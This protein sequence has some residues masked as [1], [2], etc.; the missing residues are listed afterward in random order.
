[1]ANIMKMKINP[2]VFGKTVTGNDFINR[3]QERNEIVNEIE[4]H[5]NIIIYAPRRYGK[6]SLILQAYHDL[7]QKNKKFA[8]MTIDFYQVNSIKKFIVLLTNQYMKQAG[9]S[10]ERIVSFLKEALRGIKPVITI[11]DKGQPK[12]EMDISLSESA[13]ILED[14]LELPKKLA[15][16]GMLVSVFF[17]EFQEITNLNGNTFQKQLRSII[18]HHN[19]VSYIFSGSKYHLF[20]DI[21]ITPA[22]P[23]YKTGKS[24]NLDIIPE[25]EYISFLLKHLRKIHKS[26]TKKEAE[27]IFFDSG[28]IPYNV[29][30]LAH[31][32][33]NLALINQDQIPDKIINQA[34]TNI[35]YD[36]SEEFLMTLDGLNAS[37]KIVIEMLLK[38]EGSG[39]FKKENLA[40]YNMAPSTIKKALNSLQE[41]GIIEKCKNNY[42]FQDTFFELW[43]KERI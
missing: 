23:L 41:K 11:D 5:T 19:N 36:K 28:A 40:K 8:G 30:M 4:N 33:F 10:I 43:L 1:M 2:F 17:D 38:S 39:M 16:S 34:L 32:V 37:S 12:I 13:G 20:K 14:A 21:F 29:Q 18:Q 15:D 24:R 7:K 42:L 26:F 3:Q 9:L 35:L 22:A 25:S 31:E 6:T 27:K